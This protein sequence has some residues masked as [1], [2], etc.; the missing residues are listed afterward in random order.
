[1][2]KWDLLQEFKY[3]STSEKSS[4]VIHHVSKRMNKNHK[5]IPINAGK[6]FYKTQYLFMIKTLIKAGM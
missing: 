5:I 4:N 2:I 1:M 6:I 3:D